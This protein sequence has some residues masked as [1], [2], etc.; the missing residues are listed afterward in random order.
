[1][2][3]KE[4]K[5]WRLI[6]NS[7]IKSLYNKRN[8]VGKTLQENGGKEKKK[9]RTLSLLWAGKTGFVLCAHNPYSTS[10]PIRDFF[11]K[12]PYATGLRTGLAL[13]EPIYLWSQTLLFL[14]LCWLAY[15]NALF[16][17]PHYFSLF[18]LLLCIWLWDHD[19]CAKFFLWC[20]DFL[21]IFPQ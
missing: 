8:K 6:R 7:N 12:S 18:Y 19:T 3:C 2:V 9:N 4:M 17:W 13:A 10:Q 5:I 16:S 20:C 21:I 1:M 14:P 11:T 15:T